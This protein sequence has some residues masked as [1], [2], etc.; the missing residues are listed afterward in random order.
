[1]SGHPPSSFSQNRT[2]IPNEDLKS[3]KRLQ[4][5]GTYILQLVEGQTNAVQARNT[6][7][8]MDRYKEMSDSVVKMLEARVQMAAALVQGSSSTGL[9]SDNTSSR[10]DGALTSATYATHSSTFN[11][12]YSAP[13]QPVSRTVRPI[14]HNNRR[15]E[16]TGA[17]ER[18]GGTNVT[19]DVGSAVESIEASVDPFLVTLRWCSREGI[20]YDTVIRAVNIIGDP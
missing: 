13:S 11:T 16:V 3:V 10:M 17:D 4:D 5:M 9:P 19:G 15:P 14:R 12:T 18:T 7:Q 1:M 8:A 6:Q 2:E 20:S